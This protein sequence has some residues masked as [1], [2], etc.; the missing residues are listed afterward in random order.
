M[1]RFFSPSDA[2]TKLLFEDIKNQTGIDLAKDVTL[3]KFVMDS[4]GDIRQQSL[5]EKIPLSKQ[6]MIDRILQSVWEKIKSSP[7]EKVERIMEK[8]R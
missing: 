5:L 7:I 2:N 1:K 6:G 8:N 3:A 4:V